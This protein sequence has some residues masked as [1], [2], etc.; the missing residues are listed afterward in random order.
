MYNFDLDL[1]RRVALDIEAPTVDEL[2][3][4]LPIDDIPTDSSLKAF[5][6]GPVRVW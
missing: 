1:L 2:R 3:V 4:P 5:E 6:E